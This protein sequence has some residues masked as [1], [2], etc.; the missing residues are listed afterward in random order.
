MDFFS[1]LRG[2]MPRVFGDGVG[3]W[4]GSPLPPIHTAVDAEDVD[5]VRQLA[6]T[7]GSQ[8]IAAALCRACQS[9]KTQVVEALLETGRCDVN[10]T[11]D[12]NTPLFVAASKVE[13]DIVKILL[14]NGA[15]VAIR[16]KNKRD[17]APAFTPLHG[18]VDSLR[19]HQKLE[20]LPRYEE[21]MQLLLDAGCDINAR[22]AHGNTA[23]LLAAHK[24]VPLISFLLQH[25]ADPNIAEDRGGTAAHFLHHPLD[26]PEW[27]QALMEH[28][29]RLDIVRREDG[30]TP[31]H[32]YA[33][34]C[35]LG[36]LSLFQPFVSD[37]TM[38]DGKG[39][40]L[41]HIAVSKFRLENKTVAE[42]LK[43]GVDPNH[44]NHEG[45]QAIH[46]VEASGHDLANI[47]DILCAAGAD[48]EAK[49]SRG[50]TLLT[51][52]MR[53]HPQWNCRELI[54]Y[55]ISRGANINA[56]DYKG[57][58]V[59]SYL[60]EPYTFR[61]EN[62]E[63]LLSLGADPNLANYEGDTFLH[64]L[65][66][67]FATISEDTVLLTMIHLIKMGVSPTVP[68]FRGRTPLHMLCSQSSDDLFAAL[69]EGGR[70]AIDLLLD[71]GLDMS[72]NMSDYQGIRPIHLAATVS[73][74][75]VGKLIASGADTTAC[76]KDGRNLLHIASTA[77]QSNVIG[78]LLDHY[79]SEK[80]SSMV[81]A[82]SANGRTPLH[83]ACRS[84][85]LETVKLLLTHGADVSIED[86]HNRTPL[87]A[88][89]ESIAE[90]Q[91]WE[92]ADDQENMMNTYSA[93]GIL[94]GDDRRPRKPT[95]GNKRKRENPKSL[96]WKGEIT[97]ESATIGIGRIVRSMAS[98]GALA[99]RKEFGVG[100]MY[101]AVSEGNEEMAVELDR[102]SREMNT[103]THDILS[104][105]T[106]CCLLRS[107]HLPGLLENQFKEYVSEI[108]VLPM[109][110][111]G[112]HH[113][114]AQVLEKNYA[115][116]EDK[117]SMPAIMTSLARW[118]FS[119][120]FA[121][122]GSVMPE[123]WI[124]DNTKH[125]G[126]K[127]T[128]YLLTAGQRKLPNLDVIQVM[129][130]L[131][132]ADVNVRYEADMVDKPK[133]YYQSKMALTRHYQPGD[134]IL[135][136]LAQGTHWWYEPAIRYLLQHGADPNARNAQGKTPL[137]NAVSRGELGGHRQLEITRILLEGGADPNIAATCGYTPLA[138]SAHDT[139]LFQLL[140]DHG[141]YPSQDHP[142]ELFEA[143]SSFNIDVVS[144]L[145]EMDLDC[146]T[147]VLSD[148]QR[149]WHT[150]RVQKVVQDATAVLR[151]LHYISMLP[152]NEP[153]SRDHACRMIKFL[154]ERGANSF[155][156]CHENQL[157]LH[158]I[159]AG[160]G[161]IQPWLD[162]PDLDLER[163]DPTGRTLLLA[164]ASCTT[165]TD[166]YACTVP[167]YPLRG[168]KIAP[169]LWKEDDPTRAMTL[170][171]RGADLR[172]VDNEGNNVLHYLADVQ[173]FHSTFGL[174]E[175][176]ETM[177]LFLEKA[178][179]LV[180]Q[181]NIHGQKP[182]SIAA[183][184]NFVE[185]MKILQTENV[186]AE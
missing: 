96:G 170:Y 5:Q 144:A 135:H 35:Q 22:D 167:A 150:H 180:H 47:L 30:H 140:I 53:G 134:T 60:I 25:G 26:H 142:M 101:H 166:S 24:E 172:A 112:Y 106:Q 143:L 119:E 84:G 109:I 169:A 148:E 103:H 147:T 90:D 13:L 19:P 107:R 31:L 34:K 14:Q 130:E 39:N 66:A 154:L 79:H 69:A 176:Q 139:K 111:R 40:T 138:M 100:P 71:A 48:I 127:L 67:K 146:N 91:L 7:T 163:R 45:R 32:A 85:R 63:F 76:T 104:L 132:D 95:T 49:D 57:N 129:V 179:E 152:F 82:T 94:E 55:L 86:K 181:A 118:G 182:W 83:I 3:S 56:Q 157:I 58:G 72:L 33:A 125:R 21:L 73:E 168:G 75:L 183:E 44:R 51:N 50:C 2:T 80:V 160:G 113:E 145:L 186:G 43:L 92:A 99:F 131:F 77:R 126:D 161:I 54:Q 42:L 173:C 8:D 151:P 110:L 28:G 88:C 171:E 124:N 38:T 175:V 87:D 133:V 185:Y 41:L 78:L 18:V 136:Q 149:H 117:S 153:N 159:F 122:I 61:S 114:V 9:G 120:L 59:L 102:S 37:W 89:A 121:Q 98:H 174:F 115:V 68:N 155:L 74:L 162:L 65:A 52:T 1:S 105:E 62:L 6:A 93:A 16:S 11:T 20:D 10:A 64:H 123:N 15:D 137:C 158:E 177:S 184:K 4:E 128:P 36:D 23:L 29:A 164:A 141:A 17:K 81:N 12:G 97:S 116:V 156:P 46:M 165:G 178:P 27:F 108:N 70:C